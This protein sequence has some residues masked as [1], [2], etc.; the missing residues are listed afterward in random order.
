MKLGS[1]LDFEPRYMSLA[2]KL[3]LNVHDLNNERAEEIRTVPVIYE[4]NGRWKIVSEA[5]AVS[6]Q[7]LKHWHLASMVNIAEARDLIDKVG[8]CGR[9]RK[10]EGIRVSRDDAVALAKRLSKQPKNLTEK[11]I[12][13]ACAGED[14]HGFLLTNPITIRRE[15]LVRFSWMLPCFL[16]EA[17]ESSGT[18]TPYKVVIHTRNVRAPGKGASDASSSETRDEGGLTSEEYQSE[19]RTPEQMPFYR[20]YAS[21]IYGFISTADLAHIGFSFNDLEPIGNKERVMLRRKLL[22]EAYAPMLS[23]LGA[24]LSRA[25]PASAILEL[26]VVFSDGPLPAPV[27]PIY[28]SYLER[29]IRLYHDQ[30]KALGSNLMVFLWTKEPTDLMNREAEFPRLRIVGSPVGWIGE[31]I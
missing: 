8:F 11:D 24:S 27:H 20:S 29:N 28:P 31:V 6:G 1:P 18:V 22:I 15:S 2:A 16:E 14:V 9:C 12:I 19:R 26:M 3:V 23:G 13:E 7:M 25:L 17:L 10:R 5:V 30:A 21:G 4:V